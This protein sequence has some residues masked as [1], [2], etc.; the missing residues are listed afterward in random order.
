MI[1]NLEQ[2]FNNDLIYMYDAEKQLANI[3]PK[4]FEKTTSG[5]LKTFLNSH[6]EDNKNHIMRIKS[7]SEDVGVNIDSDG[8]VSKG[9][10]GLNEELNDLI[11]KSNG[12]DDAVL[13]AALISALQ[14]IQHYEIASYGTLRTYAEILNKQS[15]ATVFQQILDEEKTADSSLTDVAMRSV[16]SKA[17]RN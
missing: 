7:V 6:I 16:N 8:K 5:E 15:A 14:R 11:D 9:M 13:D 12:L 3:M 4:V 17:H 1:E 2:L 10:K